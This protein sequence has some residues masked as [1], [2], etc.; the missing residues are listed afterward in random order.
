ML[1]QS[2]NKLLELCTKDGSE[3]IYSSF[4]DF[5]H[6]LVLIQHEG[7]EVLAKEIAPGSVP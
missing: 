4:C 1:K 6:K 7:E 5:S 2:L 3:F